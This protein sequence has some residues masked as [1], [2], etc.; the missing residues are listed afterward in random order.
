M[1]TGWI[2]LLGLG[3][4]AMLAVWI[5]VLRAHTVD[6]TA[7]TLAEMPLEPR[8]LPSYCPTCRVLTGALEEHVRRTHH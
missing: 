5:G 6:R 1:A 7:R 3:A 8:V 4:L 2:V